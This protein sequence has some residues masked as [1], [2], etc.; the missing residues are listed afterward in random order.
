MTEIHH[1]ARVVKIDEYISTS[2]D[3]VATVADNI[4]AILNALATSENDH[5]GL[6]NLDT[7]NQHPQAAVT[8]LVDALAVHTSQIT[9]LENEDIDLAA[10]LQQHTDLVT[11]HFEDVPAAD[12]LLYFRS[13]RAWVEFDPADHNHDA[14][15][16]AITHNHDADYAAITHNHDADYAAL[17][18]NHDLDYD[19]LG[20]A[21]TVQSNLDSHD[22]DGV[23]APL[24]SIST[25]TTLPS[26]A[27]YAEGSIFLVVL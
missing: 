18:H 26:P 8:G 20:A 27:G 4:D 7:P 17:V 13:D 11:Q 2:Y 19:A 23:Y 22:H 16:S 15:Y 1:D 10:L 24:G 12:G 14:L 5:S 25:G 9:A 21:A 6:I 3:K